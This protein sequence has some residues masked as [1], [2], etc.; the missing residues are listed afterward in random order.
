MSGPKRDFVKFDKYALGK[1]GRRCELT[2]SQLFLLDTLVRHADY[3]I[4]T[5]T[6]SVTALSRDTLMSRNTISPALE[7]LWEKRLV[8]TYRPMG[9]GV[10]GVLFVPT[11]M[12]RAGVA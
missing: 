12:R 4:R 8:C 2:A 11:R 7:Q 9:R 5:Y 1:L 3:E 6:G 10:E